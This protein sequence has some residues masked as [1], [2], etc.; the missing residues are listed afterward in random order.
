MPATPD[1]GH[2][3]LPPA[4]LIEAAVS[5]PGPAVVAGTAQAANPP[6]NAQLLHGTLA[7]Q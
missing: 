3:D 4:A 7:A 6:S 2:H 1:P 5:W